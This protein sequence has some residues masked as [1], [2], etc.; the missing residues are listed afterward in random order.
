MR[1]MGYEDTGV[2]S[3]AQAAELGPAQHVFERETRDTAV[4][5]GGQL[6]GVARGGDKELRL[7]LGEDTARGPQPGDDG[8]ERQRQLV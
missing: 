1:R 2:H 3:D 6:G 8:G 7:V 5:H 4:D